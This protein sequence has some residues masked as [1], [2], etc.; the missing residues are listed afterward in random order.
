MKILHILMFA[1]FTTGAVAADK[2]YDE[3]ADAKV[4]IKQALTQAAT[5]Q[6]PI[7]LV[8]GANWCPDCLVL[9]SAMEKGTSASLLARDFKIVKIDVGRMNKNLELAYSYGVPVTNGIPAVAIISA[10]NEVLYATK[11]GELSNA[12]K[13]GESGIYEFFKRVTEKSKAKK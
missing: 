6:L 1:L 12:R 2:P 7:I 9:D 11:E 3:N 5:N 13:M 8:F 10:R 4:E